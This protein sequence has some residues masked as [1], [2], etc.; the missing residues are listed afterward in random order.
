[1]FGVGT[2]IM[3]GGGTTNQEEEG[4]SEPIQPVIIPKTRKRPNWLKA[5]LE[6]AKG[7]GATKGTFRERKRS[8]RY[9]E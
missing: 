9:S 3:F 2:F 4:P 5:T 6:D 7:H 8:K 1:M